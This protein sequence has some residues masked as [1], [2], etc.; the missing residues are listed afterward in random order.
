MDYLFSEPHQADKCTEGAGDNKAALETICKQVLS[1]KAQNKK[2]WK[3]LE[4]SFYS[5]PRGDS[6]NKQ[7]KQNGFHVVYNFPCQCV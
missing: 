4:W 3:T 2:I 5:E 1:V 7:A 6:K